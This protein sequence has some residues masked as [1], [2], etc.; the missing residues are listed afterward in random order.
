MPAL[1][2][3]IF[4]NTIYSLFTPLNVIAFLSIFYII[5]HLGEPTVNIFLVNFYIVLF[6]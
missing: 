3:T 4:H 2:R 5:L 1:P 6:L